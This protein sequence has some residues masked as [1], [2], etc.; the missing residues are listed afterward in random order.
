M[1]A[2][3]LLIVTGPQGSGNHLFSRIF[4]S[5]AQVK[6]WEALREQYWVPSDEEPFA[7]FWITP[8]AITAAVFADH[9]YFLANVS[10]PFFTMASGMRPRSAKWRSGPPAWA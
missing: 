2:K 5:H 3:R 9:D 10:Y 7:P 4:S 1:N 6:G 8:D